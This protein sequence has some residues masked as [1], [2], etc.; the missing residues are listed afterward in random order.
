LFLVTEQ[1]D[2]VPLRERIEGMTP[3][4]AYAPALQLCETLQA[5][6]ARQLVHGCLSLET[7]LLTPNG[8]LKLVGTGMALSAEGERT[9]LQA[10]TGGLA[11]DLRDLGR[12]LHLLFTREEPGPDGRVARDLLPAFALVLRRCL[13]PHNARPIGSADEVRTALIEAV[14]A[15]RPASTPAPAAPTPRPPPPP[16][17]RQ[18]CGPSLLQRLDAFLWS[19][20]KVGLHLTI[21]VVSLGSLLLLYHFKDR[22]VIEERV[23]R[24]GAL[25]PRSAAAAEAVEPPIPAAVMGAL[26]APPT[27]SVPPAEISARPLLL[28]SAPAPLDALRARYLA[29][30]QAAAQSALDQLLMEDLPHLQRELTL[31][32]SG[33]DVPEQDEPG[34]SAGLKQLRQ[35]YREAKAG[36]LAGQPAAP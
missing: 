12:T 13:E 8:Q 18:R 34:L 19:G 36:I 23:E 9:W 5:L 24:P 32:Q 16:A 14:Q 4:Q 31:L 25:P 28:P 10:P 35:N 33:A 11:A 22:I 2:G 26:P 1:V 21:T 3:K 30:V 29:S 17:P 7:V 15:G 27:L 6:H 20:L